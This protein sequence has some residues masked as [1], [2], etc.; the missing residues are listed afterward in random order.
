[1]KDLNVRTGKCKSIFSRIVFFAFLAVTFAVVPF[2]VALAQIAPSLGTA[3]SFAALAASTMII[4]RG[5]P[6]A[7]LNDIAG[8]SRSNV[9]W[10]ETDLNLFNGDTFTMPGTGL[11]RVD[12]IRLWFVG[13][14]ANNNTNLSDDTFLGSAFGNLSLYVGAVGSPLNR[15]SL[16]SFIPGSD[17]TSNSNVIATRV[18]YNGG[19]GTE[20][21][22]QNNNY[23]TIVQIDF[24]N[25]NLEF[26]GGTQVQFG[27]HTE[28]DYT[29]SHA[30]NAA[31]SGSTQDQSDD[32][33]RLFQRDTDPATATFLSTVDSNVGGL[34][35]KSS[36]I[37]VQVI[38]SL[39]KPPT[40]NK[41]FNPSIINLGD[42]WQN[43]SKLT[44]TLSNSNDTV[45]NLIAPF[46][47]I[48]PPGMK[49]IAGTS[50]NTCGGITTTGYSSVTLTGGS[51]PANGSCKITVKVT[52]RYKGKFHNKIKA[53]DLQT[54]KGSNVNGTEATLTAI[55]TGKLCHI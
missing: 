12:T 1:M 11:W 27:M 17:S 42:I 49:V 4:D 21:D 38:A 13:Y 3:E 35:D 28:G 6:T 36:D 44:I 32:L 10:G 8:A 7:N 5:L 52:A 45:A 23:Y 43:T 2:H 26:A 48:M 47:D 50:T 46:S 20:L 24:N 41:S 51:I 34:W 40:I 9:S 14:S 19:V 22:Y 31:L 29:L 55:C 15:V 53:G 39:V 37:N 25:L 18:Q 54:N 30:S 33:F 16:A